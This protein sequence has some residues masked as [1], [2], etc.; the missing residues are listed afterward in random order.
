LAI[1]L[2]TAAAGAGGV[3][4]QGDPPAQAPLT[5]RKATVGSAIATPVEDLNLK[6]TQIPEVLQKA[7]AN[8]YDMA[9]TADCAAIAAEIASLDGALG[10]DKD[11]PPSETPEAKGPGVAGVLKA[12]V[13]AVIPYRGI[14]R[15]VSGAN[16]HEKTVSEA[17][18]VGF[19]RRGF[20][21][22]RAIEMNCPAPASPAWY[23]PTPELVAA[24][25]DIPPPVPP[26]PELAAA[27]LSLPEPPASSAPPAEAATSTPSPEPAPAPAE[28]GGQAPTT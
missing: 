12:G 26:A 4:A 13:Q 2:A 16:A 14:V 21:K 9:G 7:A 5:D 15:Q 3:S 28:S 23:T 19:A 8:P 25:V 17:V 10:A 18:Q 6:K 1:A 20:L 27:P 22:G 11:A 24:P